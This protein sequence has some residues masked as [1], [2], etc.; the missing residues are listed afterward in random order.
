[1]ENKLKSET[2][3]T[4]HQ[5]KG[6]NIA[7]AMAT[8]DNMLTGLHVARQCGIV[9]RQCQVIVAHVSHSSSGDTPY[10]HWK[11]MAAS[12]DMDQDTWSPEDGVSHL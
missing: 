6:A 5:L 7:V 10:I 12:Q 11:Y 8:G 4:I 9:G 2:A 1:M 3:P